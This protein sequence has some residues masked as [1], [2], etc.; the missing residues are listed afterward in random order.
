MKSLEDRWYQTGGVDA[1]YDSIKRLMH[2]VAAMPTASGKS[3]VLVKLCEKYLKENK[4]DILLLSHTKEILKQDLNALE[5]YGFKDVGLYSA[6]LNS[7]TTSNI[8]VAGIQSVHNKPELFDNVGLVIVDEAHLVSPDEETM[9][10]RLFKSIDAQ[11]CGLTAT[12]YRLGSGYIYTGENAL[13]N[14]LCYD[15]T[16]FENFNKLVDEGY[17]SKLVTKKTTTRLDTSKLKLQGGDFKLNQMSNEFDKDKINKDIVKEIVKAGK[18]YKRWLVFAIDIEHAEHLEELFKEH[19]ILAKAIHSKMEDD[20]DEVL[21]AA[22]AGIIK[23]LINVDILTTGY[24]DPQIDLLAIVRPTDSPSLHVQ[25]IGRGMRVHP[26]KD[27]CLVMDFAGNTSRLG[28]INDIQ[29]CDEGFKKKVDSEN[30]PTKDCPECQSEIPSIL[31]TCPDCS[32]E[33]P[34]I[35]REPAKKL[36]ATA[37]NDDIFLTKKKNATSSTWRAVIDTEIRRKKGFAGRPDSMFVD[38]ITTAGVVHEQICYD[39]DGYPKYRAD[40]IVKSKLGYIQNL[41]MPIDLDELFKASKFF[42][43]PKLIR[44]DTKT[45]YHK[46]LEAKW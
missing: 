22:K 24:D 26:E 34:I 14:D 45:K 7:R 9:Y 41:R 35:E 10:R 43:K 30:P 11:F 15:L 16:T 40:L 8:T 20:R 46:V 38:Y 39:H 23:C 17:L 5:W 25:I 27:H 1:L 32:Y 12:P 13:F 28:A 4:K 21:N 18:N 3:I 33:F 37:S 31:K 2:P 44:A 6:G 19:D 36:T 42:R 29:I